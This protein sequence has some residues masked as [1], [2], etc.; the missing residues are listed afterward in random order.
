MFLWPY[1]LQ[2]IAHIKNRS[3]NSVIKK[4]PFEALCGKLPTIDYIRIL[5]SLTYVLDNKRAHKL[6][7]KSDRGILVGFESS[8]NYLV[9]LPSKRAVISSKNV[10]IKEDLILKDDMTEE[11]DKIDYDNIVETLEEFES[12]SD[13]TTK[14][15]SSINDEIPKKGNISEKSPID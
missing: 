12:A 3:Y 7:N 8:N 5:G 6:A 1:V 4:T 14:P 10:L 2:G 15:I 11:T 13:D 9:Y